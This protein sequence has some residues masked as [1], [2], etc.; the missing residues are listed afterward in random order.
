MTPIGAPPQADLY[1]KIAGTLL[2]CAGALVVASPATAQDVES[3]ARFVEGLR[4]RGW[5][6]TALEYLDRVEDDPLAMP[7]FLRRLDYERAK[8][9]AA[10]AR[11]EGGLASATDR[12]EQAAAAFE[13]FAQSNP[14]DPLALEAQREAAT[15]LTTRAAALLDASSNGADPRARELLERAEKT[16]RSVLEETERRVSLL[17]KPTE[18]RL[19][20]E[21]R[22]ARARLRTNLAEA[23]FSVARIAFDKARTF[24]SDAEDRKEAFRDA[25]DEFATLHERYPK[26]LIGL[27]GRFYQGRCLQEVRDYEGALDC[28]ADIVNQP[29]GKPEFRR[30]VARTYWRRAQCLSSTGK[31][32]EAIAECNDWLDD[33]SSGERNLPEWLAVAYQLAEMNLA[34]AEL[35]KEGSRSDRLVNDAR[36]LLRAVAD[37]PNQFQKLAS[38]RLLSLTR[39]KSPT[40]EPKSFAEAAAMGREA[41]ER[42]SSASLAAK[43]AAENNPE[44]APELAEETGRYRAQA[45]DA[46]R[47]GL[48]LAGPDDDPEEVNGL[49]YQLA[50][51]YWEADQPHEAAVLGEHLATNYPE[52]KHAAA[53]AKIALAA[54]EKLYQQANRDTPGD[55]GF[56]SARIA[57]IAQLIASRWPDSAEAAAAQTLLVN[58][59]LAEG[60]VDDARGL[61]ARLP[62]NKRAAAELA[63]G[64]ALW[65]RHARSGGGP[66]DP[67]AQ[68]AAE[69][70]RSGYEGIGPSTPTPAQAAG[71]L[72]YVQS[73]L[74]AGDADR[75]VEVLEHPNHG[76]L[77]LADRRGAGFSKQ[78]VS[79]AQKLALRGYVMQSPP[80][81]EKAVRLMRT[82]RESTGGKGIT[83]ALVTLG[84]ELQRQIQELRARGEHQAASGVAKTFYELLTE[85]AESGDAADWRTRS[86]VASASLQIGEALS[87]GEARPYLEQAADACRDL[88]KLAK[89]DPSA[90]PSPTA[91]LAVRKRLG[92]CLAAQGDY[93]EAL[94][95]YAEILARR[96]SMLDLQ[97]A[98]A[99]TLQKQGEAQSSVAALEQAIRG[100]RPQSGGKNLFWGW[101]R[102]AKVTNAALQR[103]KADGKEGSPQAQ[104]YREAFF[105]AQY[106]ATRAR[107]LAALAATEADRPRHL[108]TAR[109]RLAF[110]NQLYPEMGGPKWRAAFDRLAQDLEDAEP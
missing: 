21:S 90:A 96:N 66:D 44:A 100:G 12:V 19:D 93:E 80:Q 38:R 73:L 77:T 10:M 45:V 30:L 47:Q 103:A 6:D 104:R 92:D 63:L 3:E 18:V 74:A 34:Q 36:R 9:L 14:D 1:T 2:L 43:L 88:L 32:D 58:T 40:A 20:A 26:K 108:A 85:V 49:R 101:L 53:G 105:D 17:P 110:M 54:Y 22:A 72:Y 35:T 95:H 55:T 31:T 62:A 24:S 16:M 4:Q 71:I 57:A 70:L 99:A 33:T 87:P 67:A 7:G 11:A 75:A 15:V 41:L 109:K 48:G 94:D 83:G 84:A 51:L 81:R 91:V 42:M 86:W 5:N 76:P 23:Q 97:Q 50:W 37:R 69:L 25:A 52:S 79:E 68:D 29:V 98:A 27:Y 39:S 89:E 60:R 59:A 64:S 82:L 78:L 65:A 13:A 102:L 106:N 28:Y 61:L 56:E 46:M 8:T 107:Y